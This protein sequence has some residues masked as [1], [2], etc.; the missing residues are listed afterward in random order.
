[1]IATKRYKRYFKTSICFLITGRLLLLL[2]N[3]VID[4]LDVVN[5][6]F[7]HQPGSTNQR[8]AKVE[9]LLNTKG[10]YNSYIFGNSCAATVNP[11]VVEQ[12]IS[13][14][15]FY[16]LSLN[17]GTLYEYALTLHTLLKEGIP[18]S[19]VFL[20]L[21]VEAMTALHLK[22]YDQPPY[23]RSYEFRLHPIMLRNTGRWRYYIDYL[24]RFHVLAIKAKLEHNINS[25]F[26]LDM[27]IVNNGMMHWRSAESRI[28][29]GSDRYIKEIDTLN[30]NT[31]E[32]NV[33]IMRT[34]IIREIL[35]FKK[36]CAVNNINLTIILNPI[37]YN[38][39]NRL[40]TTDYLLFIFELSQ[41]TDYWNFSGYN[42]VAL[43]NRNFY[44]FRHFRPHVADLIIH[45]IFNDYNGPDEFGYY[46]TKDNVSKHL[47]NLRKQFNWANKEFQHN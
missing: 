3:Y 9:H 21:N 35:D 25:T 19:N 1:M 41:E 30:K 47:N 27:D 37:N 24:R 39:L 40:N 7:L 8:F 12:Y 20:M 10:K 28:A 23:K 22:D 2:V 5:S 16:N 45:K 17:S 33:G 32:R 4:P 11:D 6:N 42:S 44:D 34:E 46:V 15:N 29:E 43:D 38:G 26:D 18:V 14:A 31:I 36:M 13:N